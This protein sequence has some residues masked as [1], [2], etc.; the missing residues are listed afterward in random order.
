MR[1]YSLILLLVA[2]AI[3]A[4]I[5]VFPGLIQEAR[6]PDSTLE[7]DL[8]A[9][10]PSSHENVIKSKT[11]ESVEWPSHGLNDK[12]QR[13]SLLTQINR[14]TVDGLG[15]A[16]HRDM[17]TKRAQEATPIVVDGV[18]YLTSTWSRV[19]AINAL[20]GDVIWRFDPQV[21]GEWARRLCCDVVNRG[22][23][24]YQ[25]R[26]YV[27]TLDGRL[28]ALDAASG[29]KVWEQDTLIDRDR[30]YSITG[31]P[32][33]ANGKVFIGN[34]GAEFGVRGYVTAYDADSGDQVWRFFTV[35]G[36]PSLPFENPE[37]EMAA[38]TW[39]G[40][41]WWKIGGGGTVWNSIVYDAELNQLYIGVGNGSPWT[42][43][44]RSPGGGDNL[45]LSSIVAL[46]P[47]TGTMNWY[48]QTTPGDNWDYTA[49]QDMALADMVV[50]DVPRKVLLQAPKNGFF[51]VLDR[52][53]GKL[54]RAHPYTAVTWAS[55]VDMDTG[56]PVENPGA[57]YADKPTWVLPG[58]VG[59]HNWQAMSTDVEAG[60]VYIPTQE[61]ALIFTLADEWKQ[62]G[63]FDSYV[64][65][66]KPGVEL[67][68]LAQL[69]LDSPGAPEVK[70]VLKAFDPLTGETK[71]SVKQDYFWNGGV[72]A[73]AG[74]L[75]FQGD[76][77]GMLSAYDKDSGEL[78]WQYETYTAI[79]APPITYSIEGVQYLS[80]LTGGGG[81]DL[82]GD[83]SATVSYKYG[84]QGQL[85]TF[86]LGGQQQLPVPSLVDR[87]IPEQILVEGATENIVEGEKL[88]NNFC[89]SCH[90][91]FARASSGI[92]DLRL[93]P[94]ARQELFEKIV[95]EGLFAGT[96]MAAFNDVLSY[97]E[98][99][100]IHQFVRARAN[101]DRDVELGKKQ[102]ARLTWISSP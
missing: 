40:G 90:G 69:F 30:F 88:F 100:K 74:G 46:D 71:W 33:V 96:G 79:L 10:E 67:G 51:Y 78:L 91:L 4:F 12:E 55:H 41:E 29:D 24:V 1:K 57:D 73:T 72:L 8:G 47:D 48:Y 61:N 83:G 94:P 35:P 62:T 44:I 36:D 97:P 64:G 3:T 21:P 19:F 23:A 87:T 63:S 14:K 102:E 86:K 11:A 37:L 89:A 15:L 60:V 101:E 16:W 18:M 49:V 84:N 28:I 45:F 27:G 80:I 59:G 77:Q 98:V 50:D 22:V 95:L 68:R 2:A 34:G 38:E 13:F 26:V 75:V 99:Q 85:L 82:W 76:S 20:T 81:A 53:D 93:A 25:G 5:L 52:T 31:A 70:G 42:R 66:W 43:A 54:L 17:K 32:R 7:S 9:N 92:P 58:S 65:R 39:K 6:Q 56:R